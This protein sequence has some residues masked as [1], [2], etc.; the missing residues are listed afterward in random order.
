LPNRRILVIFTLTFLSNLGYGVMIPSLSLYASS[1]GASH[2]FIGLIVSVYAAAQ[3]LTQVP[4]GRLSDRI[5]R[6]FLV[7]AGFFGMTVAAA[8]FNFATQP[9]HFFFLQGLA[10]IATGFLWPP[11]MALLTDDVSPSQRGKLMGTFNTIFFIGI[12]VGPL[13]GGYIA[14]AYGYMASF[15]VWA[16]IAAFGGFFCLVWFQETPR[17]AKAPAIKSAHSP[18]ATSGLLKPG[19]WPTF[20]AGCAI[21]A[22]GGF[23][24][25]FNNA[26]LPLYAVG[27]FGASTKMIGSLMFIHGLMLAFFNLPGGMISD[28]FGRRI[29][30]FWGSLLATA[31]VLWYS[32]PS[33]FSTLL[34]AVGLAGAGSAFATPAVAALTADVCNPE[35]RGE[36]FGYFLTSFYV[37]MVFGALI[38]GF[39]SDLVGLPGAVLAWG[40]TSFLLSLTGWIIRETGVRAP[41]QTLPQE[42]RVRSSV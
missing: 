15:N 24:T 21:R 2:S 9:S 30:A 28:R 12:G 38:F 36:A 10:G 31:G 37:G 5:G 11:L 22:R 27:L 7:A 14:S 42:S 13:L 35:R 18:T 16:A 41:L 4:V 6:K 29:P 39:V 3:L 19:F 34:V 8:L 17:T 26:L 33:G 25:S 23:C 1:V 40:I 20:I 32:F